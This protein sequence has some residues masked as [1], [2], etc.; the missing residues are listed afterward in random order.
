MARPTDILSSKAWREWVKA[1]QPKTCSDAPALRKFSFGVHRKAVGTNPDTGMKIFRFT[2]STDVVDR[3]GDVMFQDGWDL[4]NY[5]K[6][7]VILYGHDQFGSFPVGKATAAEVRGDSL[8]VDV[9]F[10]PREVSE[11]GHEAYR[12]VDAGFLNAVSVGFD[13]IEFVYNDEHKGYDFIRTELL[14][15][16]LVSVPANQDAIIAAGISPE[17]VKM[18][19]CSAEDTDDAL[20]AA[21]QNATGSPSEEDPATDVQPEDNIPEDAMNEKEFAS[22]LEKALAP[23]VE[24]LSALPEKV[25]DTVATKAAQVADP[26][27]SNEEIAS[28][29]ADAFNESAT[30]E[31]GA[32]RDDE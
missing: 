11:K 29:L 1:N 6:N 24:L 15:V 12:L 30:A 27:V 26:E 7:P 25:A 5:A 17:G 10:T 22:V 31:D 4:D 20:D 28:A 3:D 9:D 23:L 16:S 18:L 19:T 2:A 13:P 21:T 32:L 14:E 8:S